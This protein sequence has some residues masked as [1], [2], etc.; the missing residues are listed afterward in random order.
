M[1]GAR[2]RRIGWRG[3]AA[4]VGAAAVGALVAGALLGGGTTA[5]AQSAS[6]SLSLSGVEPL[7]LGHYEGWAIFGDDK[8]STGKFN[9]ADDGSL[10][11]LSGSPLSSL[12]IPEESMNRNTSHRQSHSTSLDGSEFQTRRALRL[13]GA[14]QIARKPVSRRR[15]SH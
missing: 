5:N 4:A 15:M 13:R 6:L 14:H 11:S 12:T 7:S 2:M 8:V 9:V 1:I 3:A 10:V